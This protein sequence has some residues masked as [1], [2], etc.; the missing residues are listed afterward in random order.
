MT[1]PIPVALLPLLALIPF[2]AAAREEPAKPAAARRVADAARVVVLANATDPESVAL[3]RHYLNARGISE[4]RLVLLPL[5]ADEEIDW[6]AFAGRVWNPLL[7]E[8]LRRNLLVGTRHPSPD[9]AGRNRISL[10]EK[11]FDTLV[12]CKGTPLKIRHDAAL[13][14]PV[15]PPG[16]PGKPPPAR[17]PLAV[18]CAAVDSEFALLTRA[19]SRALGFEP[20]PRYA[21]VAGRSPADT[22]I[23]S[24]LDGPDYAAARRL[25]D[26]AL[27]A[28]KSGLIGRA[29]ID[30]GGPHKTGDGWLRAAAE[31]CRRM[32]FDTQVDES[33]A[34]F[35]AS[36]RFDSPAIYLGWYAAAPTGVLAEKDRPLAPGAI[37]WH[38][39]SFSA[40]SLRSGWAATLATR[41]A[42]LTGGNVYEPYLEF[43]LN[44]AILLESLAR[45]MNA[46]DAAAA[47]TPV[48]SWQGVVL[49]DPLYRPF[50]HDLDRQ[51]ADMQS[52]RDSAHAYI[53]S[54]LVHGLDAKGEKK[55]ADAI[56]ANAA[57]NLPV[58]AMAYAK[59]Q[60]D[61]EAGLRPEFRPESLAAIP[62]DPGLV[63]EVAQKLVS[64]ARSDAAFA[65]LEQQLNL[66]VTLPAAAAELARRHGKI[67]L[68]RRIAPPPPPP[69]KPAP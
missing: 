2:A 53:V 28:E 65:L 48:L 6:P 4:S 44:P 9:A 22:L 36:A 64:V 19:T 47:A 46:G 10:T 17:P 18:T 42:A 51:L 56:L 43:S 3:A 52:G 15:L 39:H 8:L 50:T 14:A 37:A 57:K 25:V 20:N 26:S 35:P 55:Q 5:P 31:G 59:L 32:A 7:D 21:P 63:L 67:E 49:G 45:G 54:R 34:L 1:F 13:E 12:L 62:E 33:P 60:R 58:L 23:I 11:A 41:G 29:Y 27:A 61:L 66:G 24:R 16:E 68:A 40:A 38:I 69:A 30:L